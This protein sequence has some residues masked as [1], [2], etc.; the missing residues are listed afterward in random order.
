[1][2]VRKVMDKAW[3]HGDQHFTST[4]PGAAFETT[5]HRI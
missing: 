1:M 5:E 4:M 3:T 2:P